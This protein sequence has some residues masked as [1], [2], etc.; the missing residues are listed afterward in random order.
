M[1][2]GPAAAGR[3][4]ERA[5]D[6]AEPDGVLLWFMLHPVP[7]LLERHTRHRTAHA[8]LIENQEHQSERTRGSFAGAFAV[9]AGSAGPCE[10]ILSA[11]EGGKVLVLATAPGPRWMTCSGSG[12]RRC[13]CSGRSPGPGCRPPG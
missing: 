8:A 13:G 2:M 6:F 12:P 11:C 3:A 4:M 10:E 1:V 7:G 5:L 9:A